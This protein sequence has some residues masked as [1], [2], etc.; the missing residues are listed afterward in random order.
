MNLAIIGASG[1]VGRKTIEILEKSKISFDKLFLVASSKSSGKKITFKGKEIEIEDLNNYDFSKAQI[2][3]FAAGS[4]IAKIWV[5]KAAKISR[6][7]LWKACPC[8]KFQSLKKSIN[9]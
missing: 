6:R 9:E 3:F 2:T 7:L 8:Q 5:S 1:N 4:Q